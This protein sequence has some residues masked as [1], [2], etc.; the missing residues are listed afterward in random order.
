[1]TMH[2]TIWEFTR[3]PCAQPHACPTQQ[4]S[5]LTVLHGR[6]IWISSQLSVM[7]RPYMCSSSVSDRNHTPLSGDLSQIFVLE[8]VSH[9][10]N[11]QHPLS[12]R[13]AF[14][15]RPSLARKYSNCVLVVVIN[16]PSQLESYSSPSQFGE[17]VYKLL[18]CRKVLHMYCFPLHHVS[19]NNIL[20]QCVSI[21]HET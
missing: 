6:I 10:C 17:D 20:S 13:E 16:T 12:A 15:I 2:P 14:S 3:S 7:R 5:F 18:M 1:M 9:S 4:I 8:N 11:H 19:E 21:Y